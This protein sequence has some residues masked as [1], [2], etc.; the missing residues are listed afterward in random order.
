MAL[1]ARDQ[2]GE[3]PFWDERTGE[4]LR[5]DIAR[6]RIHAWSPATGLATTREIAGEVSAVVPR[7]HGSGWVL[8]ADH[9]LLLLDGDVELTLAVVE[10][11]RPGNR[12]ND[13]TC[14][15]QGRLRLTVPLPAWREMKSCI[16]GKMSR[17]TS[18][19][20]NTS[21]WP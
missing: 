8:A 9:R 18:L 2:L 15:P 13:C 17:A 11:D 7:A 14:D 4:L 3:G 19:P 20:M 16:R 1:H 10:G 12:F 6:G 21:W 5:V